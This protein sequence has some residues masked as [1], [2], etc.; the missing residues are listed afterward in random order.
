MH[1]R[2]APFFFSL[3]RRLASRTRVDLKVDPKTLPAESFP[4]PALRASP[5]PSAFAVGVR[6]KK[7]FLKSQKRAGWNP[8]RQTP[9]L[10]HTVRRARAG[11]ADD[12]DD[13]GPLPE[14]RVMAEGGVGRAPFFFLEDI[15]GGR[16]GRRAAEDA[17][18]SSKARLAPESTLC[19]TARPSPTPRSA[20]PPG[21]FRPTKKRSKNGSPKIDRRSGGVDHQERQRRDAEPPHGLVERRERVDALERLDLSDLQD[22]ER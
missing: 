3:S 19:P 11:D 13:A 14:Q 5:S 21:A 20:P 16:N 4:M 7:F 6:R 1:S 15:S 12:D 9:L 18:R 17:R 22:P 2:R 10:Q 8:R